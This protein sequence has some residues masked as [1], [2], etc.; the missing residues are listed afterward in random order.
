MERGGGGSFFHRKIFANIGVFDEHLV[1]EDFDFHLRVAREYP[2]FF[3]NEALVYKRIVSN[4]LGKTPR[5]YS[6]DG[7]RILEK[8]SDIV[9]DRLGYLR[10]RKVLR[11][12]DMGFYSRDFVFG[13]E[14]GIRAVRMAPSL[15]FRVVCL[16]LLVMNVFKYPI[17]GMLGR[18]T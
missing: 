2:I 18:R 3:C 17:K 11:N 8:H 9:G 10:M 15:R 12:S 16:F 1:S 7:L 13:L 4:S 14:Q 6:D 5:A